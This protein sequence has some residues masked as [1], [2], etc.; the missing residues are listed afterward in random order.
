LNSLVSCHNAI[1]ALTDCGRSGVGSLTALHILNV[2]TVRYRYKNGA[3]IP[4][5]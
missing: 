2:T 4:D 1:T 5:P 3:L